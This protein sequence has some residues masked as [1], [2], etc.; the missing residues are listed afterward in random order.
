MRYPR[1]EYAL[2]VLALIFASLLAAPAGL[3]VAGQENLGRGRITGQVLDEARAPVE[4]AQVTAESLQ[5]GA[6]LEAM[7]NKKGYF[8]I[9]GLGTGMWRITASKKGYISA[10][11]EMNV[12]QLRSNPPVSL[13][14]QRD[15]GSAGPQAD[16]A[17]ASLLDQGNALMEKGNYDGAIA[18]FEE[19]QTKYPALYQVR[20]NIAT[21]YLKKGELDKAEAEFKGVLAKV[22]EVHADY[23]KDKTAS[24]RA[25][26]GLGDVAMKRG[27][28][29][30][31]QTC[32]SQALALSP[33]DEAA[34]YNVGEMLF[35]NQ[36]IDEAVK[37]FELAIEIKKDWPKPYYKLGFVYLNKG[38]Y[39]KSL[40]YFN[41]FLALDPANPEVPAVRNIIATIEKIKK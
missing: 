20:L 22:R 24:V 31:A 19:F 39:A 30:A 1:R 18:L 10:Y 32:L 38:D 8:A 41:K 12:A 40:E 14:L 36:K 21:A 2:P 6:K 23:A 28:M 9:A 5:G 25:L 33:E 27:D 4:G 16:Q 7:T 29:E 15:S 37:Y 13:T 35:S 11:T 26:S 34:A 17:G 3:V